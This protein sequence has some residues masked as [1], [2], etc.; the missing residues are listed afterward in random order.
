MNEQSLFFSEAVSDL[1]IIGGGV[2]GC[3]AFREF[4]L[5]GASCLLIERDPDLLDGASK[6]NSGLLHTGFD[7]D[8]GSVEA[9]CIRDG[10]RRYVE[11][12]E[13]LN[14]PLLATGA[15]VVAWTAEE[16]GRLPA[17]VA[18]AHANGVLDVRPLSRE[19]LL[20][21]EP[22]LHVEARAG[23]VVPGE[24]VIDPW[25]APLA[26]ALQ[27]VANGGTILRNAEVLGG[28]L[29]GGIWRL[30]TSRGSVKARVVVNCAGNYGDLVEA[31]ARSSPFHIRPRKGQFVVFDKSAYSLARSIILPVPSERTKGVVVCRTAFGNLL[32]GPTAEDQ[33]E[34]RVAAVEEYVLKKLIDHGRRILPKLAEQPVTAVYAGLRPATQFKDYQIEA[35]P[36][37]H[38]ITASGIRSTGLTGALGI[39]LRLRRLYEEHFAALSPI[40]DPIWTPVA[41]LTEELPRRFAQEG[42]SEIICHCESVTRDDIEGALAGPLPAATIGGLKRRTRCMMGGCQGFY[43]SRRILQVIAGRI[44]GLTSSKSQRAKAA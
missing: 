17:I 8:P 23:V 2:V 1:A 24:S 35:M 33:N 30:N 29:E 28:Q 6:G 38:W 21:R 44:P 40:R 39:A 26:Y 16:Q 5:A 42:R 3:G 34:R 37:L 32:V 19:E 9:Q 20:G 12:R 11:L 41:N 7:A 14:L 31:I 13:R 22:A 43:C 4:V 10:Y 25:S 18:Q 36:A 15:V 27:G